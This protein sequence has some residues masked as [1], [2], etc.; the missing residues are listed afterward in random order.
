MCR[1][2]PAPVEREL[3]RQNRFLASHDFPATQ[4]SVQINMDDAILPRE[5]AA[6]LD[7]TGAPGACDHGGGAVDTNMNVRRKKAGILGGGILNAGNQGA[8]VQDF[9]PW[10]D[11]NV[12]ITVDA[13]KEAGIVQ[14]LG[15]S[16]LFF[17]GHEFHP[18]YF[19]FC[20]DRS[21]SFLRRGERRRALC[22]EQS[23]RKKPRR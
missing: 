14:G 2:W 15:V 11:S 18:F 8:P 6:V 10:C 1:T 4:P 16:R 22:R 23:R 3:A 17:Q 20:R 13:L 7:A 12:V 9:S 19:H 21:I 5:I